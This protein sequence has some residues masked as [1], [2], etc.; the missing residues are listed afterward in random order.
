[1]AEAGTRLLLLR[2]GQTAWNAVGRFQG[3]ADVPLDETGRAQ[4]RAAAPA[5]AAL[6][7]VALWSSDLARASETAAII[8][9]VLGLQP[10]LDPR[11][12]EYDVGERQGLTVSEFA[13]TFPEAHAAWV[14]D[15]GHGAGTDL[16]GAESTDD[17]RGRILPALQGFWDSLAAGE[18]GLVV[19]HGAAIKLA[20]AALLGWADDQATTLRGLDNCALVDL[21]RDSRG[22]RLAGYNL[23][24]SSGLG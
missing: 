5:I 24:T 22:V 8:G 19:S 9:A 14:R 17:V 13:E 4:A 23:P 11:L 18:T 2:H 7:P 12:R 3:H 15:G 20:T 1:M 6:A 10:T 21:R 16:P